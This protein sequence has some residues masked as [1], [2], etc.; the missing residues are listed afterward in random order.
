MNA[1]ELFA[2]LTILRVVVLGTRHSLLLGG[3]SWW[4]SI[5]SDTVDRFGDVDTF[6]TFDT[7]F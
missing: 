3:G 6:D 5:H 1:A 4:V 2:A 7:V